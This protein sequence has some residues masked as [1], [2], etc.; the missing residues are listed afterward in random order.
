MEEIYIFYKTIQN[1]TIT[2]GL[3]SAPFTNR[4]CTDFHYARFHNSTID[5]NIILCSVKEVEPH[6]VR[7]FLVM[8]A[9]S[10]RIEKKDTPKFNKGNSK[11][12]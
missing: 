7:T 2:L 9:L 5:V 1:Y 10:K 4:I 8:R 3:F 11:G 6:Y 12:T